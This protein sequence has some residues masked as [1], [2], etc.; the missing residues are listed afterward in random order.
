M[1]PVILRK[2]NI[3]YIEDYPLRMFMGLTKKIKK[4]G[5]R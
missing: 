1:G 3:K 4:K 5:E 2:E